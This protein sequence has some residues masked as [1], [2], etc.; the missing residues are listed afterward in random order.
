M[1]L[2]RTIQRQKQFRGITGHSQ[3]LWLWLFTE[4]MWLGRWVLIGTLLTMTTPS[5]LQPS[6]AKLASITSDDICM[7]FVPGTH[8][9]LYVWKNRLYDVSRR[10]SNGIPSALGGVEYIRWNSRGNRVLLGDKEMALLVDYPSLKIAQVFVRTVSAWWEDAAVARV[11]Y[12][13]QYSRQFLMLPNQ[14][15]ELPRDLVVTTA[16]DDGRMLLARVRYQK[17]PFEQGSNA[18]LI[19]RQRGRSYVRSGRLLPRNTGL[20]TYP[21]G[22]FLI[23]TPDGKTLLFGLGTV[24]FRTK[25]YVWAHS[26]DTR[27]GRSTAPFKNEPDTAHYVM[28]PVFYGAGRFTGIYRLETQ[29]INQTNDPPQYYRFVLQNGRLRSERLPFEVLGYVASPNGEGYGYLRQD[30]RGPIL[31]LFR[32]RKR[33]VRERLRVDGQPRSWPRAPSSRPT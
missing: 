8:S 24:G 22:D 19:R 1:K 28:P 27:T 25:S 33:L 7:T 11:A 32:G 13:D 2:R 30:G 26:Y 10:H 5:S 18:V 17:L 16:T 31:E 4:S 12:N 29:R 9:V 15:V 6:N 20:E 23:L 14:Q 3:S 21:Y